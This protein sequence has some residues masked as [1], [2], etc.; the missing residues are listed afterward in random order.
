MSA[1][2]AGLAIATTSLLLQ[3][4]CS[5]PATSVTDTPGKID[6]NLQVRPILSDKCFQCHGNDAKSIKAGLRLTKRESATGELPETPGKYAIVPGKP[7]SSELVRRIT[8]SDVDVRMPPKEAHK[9][10]SSSEIQTLT[11]WIAQGAEYKPH[12][13]FIAPESP[14]IPT[15]GLAA[16]ASSDIDR[17][18][19]ARLEKEAISPSQEADKERL[20]SRVTLTLTGLPADV[21]TID[22]FVNDKRPDAY[23]RRVD[24]LLAS[25]RYAEHMAAYWMDLARWSETDGFL[26]DHHD[27]FLWPWRDW[28]IRA[29][30]NNMPF[31]EFGTWQLAGDL[32]PKATEEQLLATAFLRIGKRTTE[33]GAIN[34]EYKAE[35]MIERTDNALGTAFLGLTVGCA[36][37][38]DH[39]FDPISQKAYYSLGAFFN[40]ND[41]P[42]V[43]A[44]GLSGIQGGPTLAWPDPESKQ[45]LAALD[46]QID[47]AQARVGAVVSTAGTAAHVSAGLAGEALKTLVTGSIATALA[48]SY[49]FES[50]EHAALEDLPLPQ[51]PRPAP[52]EI[53]SL[54]TNPYGP[55]ALPKP[56]NAREMQMF[57][58]FALSAR[59]PRGWVA[60][61]LDLSSSGKEGVAPAVLQSPIFKPGVQGQA[62]F[63]DE[64]NRGFLGAKV[65]WYD[66]SDAFSYSFWFYAAEAYKDVPVLNHRSEQNAGSTGYS[67]AIKDGKLWVSLAH[68]PP[69]NMIALESKAE[70][71]V[72]KWTHVVLTYD[73]SSKAAG[74]RI[75]LDGQLAVAVVDHDTL[76]RT[77]LPWSDGDVFDPFVGVAL[78][79]RF[80]EKSPVGAGIDEL[81]VFNRA[82]TPIE[83][84]Y[85]AN[86]K[87]L[88]TL[89]PGN[90]KNDVQTLLV[91]TDDDVVKAQAELTQLRAA[92]N[93]LASKVPQILVM[94]E[95]SSPVHTFVLG[96]GLYSAPG[97]EVQPRGL[98][99]V[100]KWDESLPA[101]RLGLARWLFDKRNPLTARVFVNRVWQMHFG[102]GLVETSEDFG[103]QGSI[104]A[105]P[106]LLDYL[107][108]EFIKSGW[109]IKALH[110]RIVT[111]ATYRQSSVVS[112]EMLD[113]DPAN[114]LLARGP[115]WRMTAEMIRDRALV[116]SG[117]LSEKIGGPSV[118]PYQPDGIWT[119]Q[120]S[121]YLYPATAAV[122][123]ADHHRRTLYTFIKRNA[124][125]PALAIFDFTNRTESK[126]RR[127]S[128]NT[129]LQALDL[130][131]DPQFME[132][133]RGLAAKVL[134]QGGD[135][136]SQL[137][138]LFRMAT[139]VTPTTGQLAVVRSYYE[140]Q[141]QQMSRS[142]LKAGKL[143]AVG[144]TTA[145]AKLKLRDL[146]AM[147]NVAALVMNLPESYMI[148]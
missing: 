14:V 74:T 65:G 8:S 136:D 73:G 53:V 78:G 137:T 105:N 3:T 120:N 23:E 138:L 116:T 21:E 66:R 86:P 55:P 98:D 67:I 47:Q 128:A 140:S 20:I 125:H 35:T 45:T 109:D 30:Q 82:L 17:L 2:R 6:F 52:R 36:R 145:N 1:F 121:V 102:R 134:A 71:P 75:Y 63:F 106:Q 51:P 48:A 81:R 68:S 62:L 142:P 95:Q 18:V 42:G 57:R 38:H 24:E 16:R 108:V 90:L 147:T 27:R 141:I 19:Y 41:E 131:N 124:M 60:E 43:Y 113:K 110:R 83:I 50:A 123:A 58:Q 29:F 117:L 133:Y 144:V 44:P 10:L 107:A 59:V 87:S 49:S 34:E 9:T 33:N 132:A 15:T 77:I 112:D 129:P 22:R 146:A 135:A 31:N 5:K 99:S 97:D 80:R 148:Q 119:P 79:G 89:A 37:C 100:F 101:N 126:A 122:P 91:A 40:S 13:A 46:K 61:Q 70:F 92:Q 64:T 72:K 26:D 28:V 104:P 115:S 54:A 11:T 39:K 118:M 94:R 25:P 69:A 88:D 93:K 56:R 12:W 103:M 130:M 84:R 139:R 111:S 4:G 127:S 32:L 85:L 7:Q 143:L 96:R 76:T 114:Q